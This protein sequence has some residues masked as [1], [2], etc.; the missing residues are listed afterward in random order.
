MSAPGRPKRE[1][2]PRGGAARSAEG[3]VSRAPGRPKRESA[4]QATAPG[5]LA[6]RAR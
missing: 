6:A 3:A 2:V 4:M 1:L 5:P